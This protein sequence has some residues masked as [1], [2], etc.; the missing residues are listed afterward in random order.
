MR[1]A[2]TTDEEATVIPELVGKYEA[3][4]SN[5]RELVK[6]IVLHPAYRRLP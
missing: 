2:P 3:A 5:L 6:A 4:H 1:R